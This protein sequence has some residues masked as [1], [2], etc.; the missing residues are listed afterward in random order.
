MLV[1]Q[2]SVSGPK[3][4]RRA[5]VLV[6]RLSYPLGKTQIFFRAV[7]GTARESPIRNRYFNP[8]GTRLDSGISGPAPK[9]LSG[10]NV[11]LDHVNPGR[12]SHTELASHGDR[13]LCSTRREKSSRGRRYGCSNINDIV[14]PFGAI[15]RHFGVE[16]P[17]FRIPK[18]RFRLTISPFQRFYHSSVSLDD[19]NPRQ[20]RPHGVSQSRRSEVVFKSAQELLP[21]SYI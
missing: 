20:G 7:I 19:V 10:S 3:L 14:T 21:R 15:R 1:L 9:F 2:N 4:H 12:G 17:S 11:S 5:C 18:L 13:K 8:F 16:K 6:Y